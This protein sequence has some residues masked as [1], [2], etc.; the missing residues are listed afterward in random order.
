MTYPGGTRDPGGTPDNYRKLQRRRNEPVYQQVTPG[1]WYEYANS[2][3]V[4]YLLAFNII[5]AIA[6][7]VGVLLTF[8]QGRT[9]LA[10]QVFQIVPQNFG[11]STHPDL[12]SRLDEVYRLHPTTVVGIFFGLSLG[13][14]LVISLLLICQ[15]LLP[16]SDFT[17]WY[18]RC[19][20]F[21]VAPWVRASPTPRPYTR[22]RFSILNMSAPTDQH[23]FPF[24][25]ML[26][27]DGP[28]IS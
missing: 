15:L 21:C 17:T 10:L 16:R 22:T 23:V 27:S 20:Y 18:M 4:Y 5:G 12:R 2:N 25:P 26:L 7:A 14:H 9:N 11:N 6:H 3:L 1:G 28:S 8:T 24:V 19:L 13:F